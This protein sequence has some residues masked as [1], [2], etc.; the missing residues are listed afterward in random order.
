MGERMKSCLSCGAEANDDEIVCFKCGHKFARRTS[1]P[2]TATP[3]EPAPSGL[4]IFGW[5][6]LLAGAVT[7]AASFAIDTT[8]PTTM[9]SSLGYGL[10][11]TTEINNLGLMQRQ[12]MV[13]AIGLVI[14]LVGAMFIA[15]GA[16]V[17]ELRKNTP[18]GATT[19]DGQPVGEGLSEG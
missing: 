4:A 18:R 12:T 3:A 11:T 1:A 13:L 17:S 2:A 14:A 10:T 9:P 19:S 15:A 8:V 7:A 6:M 5:L 16:V